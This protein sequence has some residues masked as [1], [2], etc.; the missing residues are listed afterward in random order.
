MTYQEKIERLKGE[1]NG[2]PFKGI[3][4]NTTSNRFRYSDE[5]ED[6]GRRLDLSGFAEVI[7][8]DD[9]DKVLEVEGLVT[10]EQAVDA[11]LARGLLPT[12]SPELK[13]I[14]IGGA[15]VGIGIESTGFRHG[16]VH[17]GLLEADVLT[18][19]GEIV[20]CNRET[21][22][23][24]FSALPNSYG[25]L[26]YILRAKIK[27]ID[28]KPYVRVTT[29]HFESLEQYVDAFRRYTERGDIDFLEGL[30]TAADQL[31]LT[32]GEM[33]DTADE[34][35]DI[36][37]GEQ[38]YKLGLQTG[39]HTLGT[40]DYIF[41]FDPDWFW[42][43]P[44]KGFYGLFRQYAPLSLRSSKFYNR[45]VATKHKLR[46][47]LRL[48]PNTGEEKLIQD[49][50]V[51]W[52]KAVELLRFA[53]ENVDLGGHPWVALPIRPLS[54]PTLYPVDPKE[55][56]MN[57]GCYCYT[58]KPRED[59]DYHYTRILDEKCFELGGIKML[60]SST[61]IDRQRFD[62]IYNGEGYRKVKKKYDPKGNFLGLFEKVVE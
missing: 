22:N 29:E 3:R 59:V 28:A 7:N 2:A 56:Y 16:F 26:G 44:D 11:A 38:Y 20:T 19:T 27:L 45:Y 42:N 48:P 32:T 58:R 17:D 35:T 31:Y 12:V 49:W 15:T 51:P 30:F 60:Y 4:K 13:H 9:Q 33:V 55:L 1:L 14:T 50:E 62:A 6:R 54:A 40:K 5:D 61:F 41:R 39:T 21:N 34:A 47:A 36:Y 8:V 18:S 10:F 37:R 23:D 25:T 53:L 43:V 24:L 57:L 52:D 46:R